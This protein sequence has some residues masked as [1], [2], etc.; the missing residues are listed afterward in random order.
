MDFRKKF[1]V[2]PHVKFKLGNIDPAYTGAFEND[3]SVAAEIAPHVTLQASHYCSTGCTRKASGL[4]SL[5]CKA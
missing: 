1:F 3:E 2:K 4:F 5:F